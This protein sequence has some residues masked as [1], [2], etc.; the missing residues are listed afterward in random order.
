MIE[1]TLMYLTVYLSKI[2]VTFITF[3]VR[4]ENN[5][6]HSDISINDSLYYHYYYYYESVFYDNNF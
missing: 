3:F 6:V 1:L 5:F 2:V 4:F